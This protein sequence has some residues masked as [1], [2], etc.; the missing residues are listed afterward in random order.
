MAFEEDFDPAEADELDKTLPKHAGMHKTAG[1]YMKA[2]NQSI[3]DDDRA[4][5]KLTKTKRAVV[6]VSQLLPAVNI[7]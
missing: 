4:V 6:E 3:A 1:E 5:E 7:G 2:W